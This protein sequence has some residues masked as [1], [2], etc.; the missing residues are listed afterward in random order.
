MLVACVDPVLC[1]LGMSTNVQGPR[2]KGCN[3]TNFTQCLAISNFLTAAGQR[4]GQR[5]SAFGFLRDFP[6]MKGRRRG[7]P[8]APSISRL[9]RLSQR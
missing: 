3:S 8:R 4:P 9:C 5:R 7:A 2:V 6:N 1:G